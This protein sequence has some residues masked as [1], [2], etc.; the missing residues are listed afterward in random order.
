MSYCK[1]FRLYKVYSHSYQISN[2]VVEK[3]LEDSESKKALEEIQRRLKLHRIDSLL[4]CPIQRLPRYILLIKEM[5]KHTP[6]KHHEHKNLATALETVGMLLKLCEQGVQEYVSSVNVFQVLEEIEDVPDTV[7][8]NRVLNIVEM[9]FGTWVQKPKRLVPIRFVLFKDFILFAMRI[10]NWQKNSVWKFLFSSNISSVMLR[11]VDDDGVTQ[12]TSTYFLELS[13]VKF[14]S[15]VLFFSVDTEATKNDLYTQ[16]KKLVSEIAG[17]E[18][19]TSCE[20]YSEL[21]KKYIPVASS[22]PISQV[23]KSGWIEKRKG[24]KMLSGYKKRFLVAHNGGLSYYTSQHG[25]LKGFIATDS[26]V[27]VETKKDELILNANGSYYHMKSEEIKEWTDTIKHLMKNREVQKHENNV[28]QIIFGDGTRAIIPLI[29]DDT[30]KSVLQRCCNRRNLDASKYEF[31][32]ENGFSVSPFAPMA[33]LRGQTL[34]IVA[35]KQFDVTGKVLRSNTDGTPA[36]KQ[37]LRNSLFHS[38]SS[39]D[40]TLSE[41]E[42]V[43]DFSS[44]KKNS[45]KSKFARNEAKAKDAVQS[46]KKPNAVMRTLNL[47]KLRSNASSEA[48]QKSPPPKDTEETRSIDALVNPRKRDSNCLLKMYT[49]DGNSY[50]KVSVSKLAKGEEIFSAFCRKRSLD[51]AD[52]VLFDVDNQE[53]VSSATPAFKLMGKSVRV[54][55]RAVA[56]VEVLDSSSQDTLDD[57]YVGSVFTG[58]RG[59]SPLSKT[60]DDAE[61]PSSSS[62]EWSLTPQNHSP[63][64]LTQSSPDLCIDPEL[65]MKVILRFVMGLFVLMQL[66]F[67]SQDKPKKHIQFLHLHGLGLSLRRD[68]IQIQG[69][70]P[71]PQVRP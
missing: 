41:E 13:S 17:K 40:L 63:S 39:V 42:I 7:R 14:G 54:M 2:K 52:H 27:S 23:I 1:E 47:S 64:L 18:V 9:G 69:A 60:T 31:F 49:P 33:K 57:V 53:Y 15:H 56:P 35:T 3:M 8:T 5:M 12:S 58:E 61:F 51:P 4:V 55:D 50:A 22:S 29:V 36:E 71:E 30:A 32:L 16:W 46:P 59:K 10:T 67:L 62:L 25:D 45:I 24:E 6:A 68:Q 11:M 28:V 65:L 48:E 43:T 19:D 70:G 38:S 21:F 66:V 34:F 20:N 44:K 26:M 37:D